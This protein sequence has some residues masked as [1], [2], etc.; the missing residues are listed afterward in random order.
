[1]VAVPVILGGVGSGNERHCT[2]HI[3]LACVVRACG[4]RTI[5][6]VVGVAMMCC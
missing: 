3:V 6:C 5:A 4:N 2:L 1:M